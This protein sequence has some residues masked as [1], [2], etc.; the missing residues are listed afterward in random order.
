MANI[1]FG[2]KKESSKISNTF[3]EFFK[4]FAEVWRL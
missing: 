4:I 1:W 3:Y 2:R